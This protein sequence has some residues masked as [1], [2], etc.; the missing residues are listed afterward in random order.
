M[1]VPFLVLTDT[2]LRLMAESMAAWEQAR[3]RLAEALGQETSRAAGSVMSQLSV[4]AQAAVL[5]L[6]DS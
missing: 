3:T 5:A 6:S 2:G 1:D 4:A